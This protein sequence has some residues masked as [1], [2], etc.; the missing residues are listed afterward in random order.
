[1]KTLTL[2]LLSAFCAAGLAQTELPELAQIKQAAE[3]G[4]AEAQLKL[5][6]RLYS[7][8]E[9]EQALIWYRKAALLGNVAAQTK[10]GNALL[11]RYDMTPSKK[12]EARVIGAEAIKWIAM[13]A[14]QNDR[15]A[16]ATLAELFLRGKLVKLDYCEA[17]KW[18]ELAMV[19]G[20]QDMAYFSGKA[21]R[22]SAILKMTTE[23][24]E[25]AR[26]RVAKFVPI[27]PK[28]EEVS[29]PVWVKEIHLSG[30]TGKP[31]DRLAVINNRTFGA[32]DKISLKLGG[33]PVMVQC[34]EIRESSV[35]ISVE[36]IPG[37][38]ELKLH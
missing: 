37:T 32:G 11:W 30:I 10:A 35:I 27:T 7:H 1:M 12:P 8:G 29:E 5:G 9:Q 31:G 15:P 17:Y 4:D 25:D 33:K 19:G 36:G 26:Q 21:T 2:V 23:Q 18:G 14:H 20:K 24:V 6:E 28:P 22:D 3:S 34:Q 38:R 16:Q 13:A